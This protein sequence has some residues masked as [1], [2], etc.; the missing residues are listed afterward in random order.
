M[1]AA[2]TRYIHVRLTARRPWGYGGLENT[3]V[4]ETERQSLWRFDSFYPHYVLAVWTVA[5]L[6]V[7]QEAK[8][9]IPFEDVAAMGEQ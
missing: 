2:V 4:L 5:S 3:S 9:S 1:L 6:T 8:G 7:N